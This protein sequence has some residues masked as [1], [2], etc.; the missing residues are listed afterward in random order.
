MQWVIGKGCNYLFKNEILKLIMSFEMV[1]NNFMMSKTLDDFLKKNRIDQEMWAASR[2]NWEQLQL[3]GRDYESRHEHLRDSAEFFARVIQRFPSV[4]SVRWR[5]KDTDHL[6]EKIVRK[7]SKNEVKYEDINENNYLSVVTD[8]VGLRALHLF[9]DECFAI[10][11]ALRSVW[12]PEENP[13]A[14]I[15]E[16]DSG[17]WVD[18]FRELN[19]DVENHPAGYRS[20]HFVFSTQPTS[21]KIFAEVQVRTIFEEGWSE[22]DHRVR[23]PNFSDDQLVSYF[24]NIFNRMAGSADEMG[25]YVKDLTNALRQSGDELALAHK[26]KDDALAAMEKAV[27]EL[28]SEKKQ[29]AD[30]QAHVA[31]LQREIAK[32]RRSSSDYVSTGLTHR[33]FETLSNVNDRVIQTS[34]PDRLDPTLSFPSRLDAERRRAAAESL[35]RKLQQE[36]KKREQKK[37]TDPDTSEEG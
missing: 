25:A 35:Q 10:Y 23:Y 27:A 2:L 37:P 36:M 9:K 3:I 13:I 20:V 19:F 11:E 33:I 32:L 4:H 14:Y 18:N 31:T 34:K 12:E 17:E 30:T 26:E 22:I 21:R 7:R 8:L 5:I 28:H 24:L 6:L 1:M 16:G 29:G 15:R